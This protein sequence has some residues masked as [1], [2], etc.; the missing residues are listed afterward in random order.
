V[1]LHFINAEKSPAVKLSSAIVSHILTELEVVCLPANL[2]QFIEVDLGGMLA[3]TTLH[4]AEI[5]LPKGV[6]FAA[7]GGDANPVVASAYVKAGSAASEDAAA[8]AAPEAE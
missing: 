1:P 7:H 8:S 6:V 4:L 3:G 5:T 2:P